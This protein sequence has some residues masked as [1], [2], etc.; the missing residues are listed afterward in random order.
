MSC[1]GQKPQ[2]EML[3]PPYMWLETLP[4]CATW[5]PEQ[6][7]R[8]TW[9]TL[10]HW[11]RSWTLPQAFSMEVDFK[12][13]HKQKLLPLAS[14]HPAG[15]AWGLGLTRWEANTQGESPVLGCV[16]CWVPAAEALCRHTVCWTVS[17]LLPWEQRTE[18]WAGKLLG[19]RGTDS[20]RCRAPQMEFPLHNH[21]KWSGSAPQTLRDRELAELGD[22]N[23]GTKEQE[24]LDLE[25]WRPAQVT[26]LDYRKAMRS[27]GLHFHLFGYKGIFVLCTWGW[28]TEGM[29][30]A[31]SNWV[32]C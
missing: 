18:V 28:L 26:T 7:Q 5:P 17:I 30:P 2:A 27:V 6:G 11:L 31:P 9:P 32:P 19:P 20:L 14:T 25:R 8:H 12:T 24:S 3:V 15:S 23:S 4:H 22:G 29:L 16:L 10:A 1:G 21:L 13:E